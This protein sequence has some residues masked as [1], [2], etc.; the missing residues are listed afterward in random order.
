MATAVANA[1]V[2]PVP[3]VLATAQSCGATLVLVSEPGMCAV[4]LTMRLMFVNRG[5]KTSC[6]QCDTAAEV[7]RG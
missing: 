5:G 4:C 1:V 6:W 2:K 3:Q 7:A